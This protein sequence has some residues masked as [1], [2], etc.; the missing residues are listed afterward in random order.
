MNHTLGLIPLTA[1]L[2]AGPALG[3]ERLPLGAVAPEAA[4]QMQTAAGAKVS[5]ASAKGAKGTLVIFTCNHCPWVKAWEKRIAA[6]GNAAVKSGFGVVAINSNDPAKVPED[7]LEAM[8][9]RAKELG[10]VFPYAVDSTSGIARAFGASKTPEI[11]LF[12][13]AGKLVYT[14]AVDDNAEK[15]EEVKQ[16]HLEEALAS[17]AAGKPVARPETKALGCTIKWR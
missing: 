5:I 8:A 10:L 3:A 11:F 16:K 17:V 1:L 7:S 2:V 4:V 6:V 14:G 13:V 15:P 12:D 9:V